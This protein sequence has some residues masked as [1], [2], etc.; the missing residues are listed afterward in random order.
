MHFDIKE[1]MKM[2]SCEVFRK[3]LVALVGAFA[4]TATV[5]ADTWTWTGAQDNCWTNPANWTVGGSVPATPPGWYN[6]AYGATG[7]L[8][9]V[10]EFGSVSSD[11]VRRVQN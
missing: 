4:L 1:A 6:D 5:S 2:D 10:A 9:S 11:E 3:A 8:D 7:E